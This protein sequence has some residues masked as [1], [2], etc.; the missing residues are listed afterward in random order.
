MRVGV[1]YVPRLN[2]FYQWSK[3]DLGEVRDDLAA[4]YALGADHVRIF[5]LWQLLQP[6]RKLLSTAAIDDVLAMVQVAQEEGLRVTVDAI[7]GHLSSYDFLPAWVLSWHKRGIF[8]D[9]QVVAAQVALVKRI[10]VEIQHLPGADGL[11][12]GN[13]IMQ[14][15]APRHPHPDKPT[16]AQA[17]AWTQE[18]LQAAQTAWPNGTHTCSFDDDLLFEP[19][20]PFTPTA[21]LAHQSMLTVH[22]WV[23][24]RL[25]KHLGPG[26]PRLVLFA[27]Y[28]LEL[29]SAWGKYLG[30]APRLWLQEVGAP[31]T[32][33]HAADAPQFLYDTLKHACQVPGLEAITW[34]CSHDVSRQ[35]ADFPTVE[36]D[37]GLFNEHGQVKP[38]GEAFAQM[39]NELK[40]NPPYV[41]NSHNQSANALYIPA[42]DA[43][44]ARVLVR[45]DGPLFEAWAQ[46]IEQ[47]D[48]K[49]LQVT[50]N[51]TSMSAD[52]ATC[53]LK[54]NTNL[55]GEGLS[56]V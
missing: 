5:P 28:L 11:S 50:P 23:F 47:G 18:I 32:Y 46:A 34:W 9:P 30:S 20:H 24:G 4:L 31:L 8:T 40:T 7:Q 33:I 49:Y 53:S 44:N 3:L 13:E 35:L 27:R 37:L 17:T 41:V 54:N 36:Y 42:P 48:P 29:V 10:A 55:Y 14:F 1:N 43:P 19:N 6:N 22:S 12:I 15:A 45:P 2:W 26:H 51:H 16:V 21:M 25:G 39:V 56:Y 38:V 52:T